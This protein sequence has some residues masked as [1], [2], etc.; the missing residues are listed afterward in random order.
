ML[1]SGLSSE[2]VLRS[3]PYAVACPLT[4]QD[5][6]FVARHAPPVGDVLVVRYRFLTAAFPYA[7]RPDANTAVIMRDLF[8][9]RTQPFASL[10]AADSTIALGEDEECAMLAEADTV[11]A[12]RKDEAKF[13]Q[14]RIPQNKIVV[15]PIAA[16]PVRDPQPGKGDQLL[17]SLVFP[18]RETRPLF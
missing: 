18:G 11:V 8:S 1:R 15:A 5:Q 2:P 3:A 10:G 14:G 6:L 4:R 12:I 17:F 9:S 13:L 7:L 16:L